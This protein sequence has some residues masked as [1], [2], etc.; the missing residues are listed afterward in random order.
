MLAIF[1]GGG[2]LLFL[3][4]ITFNFFVYVIAAGALIAM[5]VGVHYLIWG[6]WK[7]PGEE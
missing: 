3:V 5:F 2:F 4:I 6:R 1:F 7:P